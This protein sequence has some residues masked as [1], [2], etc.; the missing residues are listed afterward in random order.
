ME[1]QLNLIWSITTVWNSLSEEVNDGPQVR[2]HW[3]TLLMVTGQDGCVLSMSSLGQ[4]VFENQ[5]GE[6]IVG[7]DCILLCLS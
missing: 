2:W 3:T 1:G 6:A 5:S 4:N 7:D